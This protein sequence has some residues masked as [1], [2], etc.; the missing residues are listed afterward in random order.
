MTVEERKEKV[1]VLNGHVTRLVKE[2]AYDNHALDQWKVIDPA[3]VDEFWKLL[4]WFGHCCVLYMEDKVS[5]NNEAHLVM[6]VIQTDIESTPMTVPV[7]RW[8]FS[9]TPMQA[10][11][12]LMILLVLP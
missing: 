7:K 2:Y 5:W 9:P 3:K 6:E 12:D 1:R 4:E 11:R 8:D 10:A